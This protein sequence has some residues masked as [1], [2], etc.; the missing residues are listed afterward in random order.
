MSKPTASFD[1]QDLATLV[2]G[3]IIISTNPYAYP[4]RQLNTSLM[5]AADKSATPSAYF[6]DK[7]L[8][9]VAELGRNTR[10]LFDAAID[11]LYTALQGREKLLVLSV[12][13]GTRQ[14]TATLAGISITD[15]QGGHATLAIQFEAADPIGTDVN[16]INLFSKRVT[17]ANDNTAFVGGPLGG[18]APWQHPVITI[19][20]NSVTG[21]TGGT[22][23][24]GNPANGQQLS[25]TRTWAAADVV[26]I[27][28]DSLTPV[29]VNGLP[30]AFSGAIPEWAAGAAGSM[31]YT[32]TFTT[33]DRS[34][35]G[36]Y[37]KRYL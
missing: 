1:G 3:L 28:P 33:R 8:T 7:P 12:G 35:S 22:M 32:D 23:T 14:W 30:V 6:K 31:D 17:T 34:M 4:N 9:V 5:A 37:Y 29:L 20:L 21:G 24:I 10:E 16:S 25:I 2:P 15:A 36:L 18:S 27:N 11:T 19:T 13:S 26:V